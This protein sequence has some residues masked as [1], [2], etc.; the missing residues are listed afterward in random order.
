M[1][2]L[3]INQQDL[4]NQKKKGLYK[5]NPFTTQYLIILI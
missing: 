3:K 4:I 1:I 2:V 5:Y